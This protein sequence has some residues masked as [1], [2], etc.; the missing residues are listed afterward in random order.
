MDSVSSDL[1]F[2]SGTTTVFEKSLILTPSAFLTDRNYQFGCPTCGRRYKYKGNLMRHQKYECNQAPQFV[3][4]VEGCSYSSK[5]KGNLE[6]HFKYKHAA[7][8]LIKFE[9]RMKLLDSLSLYTCERC[10]RVYRHKASL[11]KHLKFECGKQPHFACHFPGCGFITKLKGNLDK[12][13]R[14][15]LTRLEHE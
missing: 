13:T 8:A 7:G 12:H 1:G 3:C 4:R 14:R 10:C 2:S 9:G 6:R 11:G 5:V 15:H